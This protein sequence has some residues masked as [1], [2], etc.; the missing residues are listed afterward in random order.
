RISSLTSPGLPPEIDPSKLRK[1]AGQELTPRS[2]DKAKSALLN[3]L[4]NDGYACPEIAISADSV[5]GELVARTVTGGLRTIDQITPPRLDKT[6]PRILRRYEAFKIGQR[7]D[8][9]LLAL[10]SERILTDSLFV[11]SYY[12]V[13]CSS[14]GLR[15]TQKTVEGKPRLYQMG[16]GFDSEDYTIAKVQWKDARIDGRGSSLAGTLYASYRRQSAE[17]SMREYLSASSRFY[18]RPRLDF[19]RENQ[20]Q[21]ETVNA[22]ASV[23]AAS[24]WD[25]ESLRA[26]AAVGPARQYIR[27]LRGPGPDNDTFLVLRTQW[28]LLDH[29]FEYYAGEPRRGWRAS[30]ETV[31]RADALDSSFT[32]HNISAHGEHLWNVGNYDPPLLVAGTRWWLATTYVDRR[33]AAQSG[34]GPDMRF[35]M[36]GDANFRGAPLK[37]LPNDDAGFLTAAYD[38]L[39]LRMG[40]IIA[41]GL[42]PLVFVDAAMGGRED[43]HLDP[44]VY[45][46][47]GAGLRWALPVG[48]IRATAS[49]GM[50]WRRETALPPL[51]RPHWQFFVSFG[52]EF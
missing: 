49:R 22:E 4:Q 32:A 7:F 46:A 43:A 42:Q 20:V 50:I 40:D 12:D 21:Y 25:G 45:W 9:R 41:R 11:S 39:E 1:I 10:T 35:Y 27:T 2:I 28:S 44:D 26:E 31:S 17:A 13:D 3:A 19:D 36:G 16:V 38:G 8:M 15:I 24:S 37:G 52:R 33:S 30:L 5:S 34:L 48:S 18:L 29:L 23:L 6:D 51:Y 47:P 14:S